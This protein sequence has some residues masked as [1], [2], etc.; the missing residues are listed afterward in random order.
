[1]SRLSLIVLAFSLSCAIAQEETAPPSPEGK[2]DAETRYQR[3]AASVDTDLRDALEELSQLRAKIAAEKPAIAGEANRIAA[4][5]REAKRR[6]EVA[7][8]RKDAVEAEFEKTDANL[9]QWRDE[10][11]YLEGLFADFVKNFGEASDPPTDALALVEQSLGILEPEGRLSI[12][13]GSALNA[14]G[15]LIA[16]RIADAG[17]VSWFLSADEK[18]SGILSQESGSPPR[19]VPGTGNPSAIRA[20]LEGESASPAF[21]PTLGNAV[22]MTET[23]ESLLDHI[24]QGGFWIIPILL[25]ALVAL[26]AALAKWL[27]LIRIKPFE[28][29]TVQS[30]IDA[31]NDADFDRARNT[32]ATIRHPAGAILEHGIH[33]LGKSPAATRDDLEEALFEKFL[34]TQP[35]LQRGLPLIAIASATAPLLGLLGTVTGMIETFRLINI[36]GTGDAKTLASGISEALV[37]TEFGLIVAI[38]ALILHALLSRKIMGIKSSMEMT[39]LAFL[40]GVQRKEGTA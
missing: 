10:R 13:E 6:S 12:T 20:L 1:M 35:P 16:G 31:I 2:V 23:R 25:L 28:T 39:S 26:I 34:E 27:Q 33:S 37:T 21:D 4:E 17:P 29:A 14:D 40:N 8:S 11:I 18:T 3:A 9:K 19:V 24:K 32:A 30:V 5:L 7:L 36:F 22:A 38:P 15:L